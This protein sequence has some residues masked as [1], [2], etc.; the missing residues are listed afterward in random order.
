MHICI[1][2][3][4]FALLLSPSSCQ[5]DDLPMDGMSLL[6]PLMPA[7]KEK[8][9]SVPIV[10]IE[11]NGTAVNESTVQKDGNGH[12]NLLLP[13]KFGNEERVTILEMVVVALL[14]TVALQVLM[15]YSVA[16]MPKQSDPG[17]GH[18]RVV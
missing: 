5:V 9:V 17:M 10:H 12:L 4:L 1:P 14:L 6:D 13:A 18:R 15:I 7:A 16:A 2:V 8:V 11:R 3:L